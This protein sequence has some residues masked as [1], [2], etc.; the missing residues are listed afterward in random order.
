M[1][2]KVSGRGAEG[3]DTCSMHSRQQL[4]ARSAHLMCGWRLVLLAASALLVLAALPGAASAAGW[5]TITS[6]PVTNTT[7][8]PV[9]DVAWDGS[10]L[11]MVW[12]TETFDVEV[13]GWNGTSWIAPYPAVVS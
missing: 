7:I 13:R 11:W 5:T 4:D 10:T 1:L 8:S 2:R 9:Q 3:A 12:G 6:P